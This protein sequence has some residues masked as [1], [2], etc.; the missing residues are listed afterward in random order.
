LRQKLASGPY[1]QELIRRYLLDNPHRVTLTLRPDTTMQARQEEETAARLKQL[2][3]SLDAEQIRTLQQQAQELRQAQ[4]AEDD[5][6]CL[7]TLELADIPPQ[8]APIVGAAALLEGRP[9]HWFDQPTNGIGYV[10][11]HLSA[12]GLPTTQLPL[13]P[14]FCTLLGQIGAAGYSYAEMAERMEAA[15]GGINARATIL[16]L[17]D[18]LNGSRNLISLK[19]KA[20]IRNQGRMFEILADLCRDPDFSDLK[21]LHTV[22]NQVKTSLENSIPGSG[23]SYAARSAAS[24]LTPGARLRELWNGM[25]QIQLIKELAERAPE[26]LSD[27][28]GQM[29]D[30]A[31]RLLRRE[32]ISC[33][34][35]A[36]Q[37][38]FAEISGPLGKFFAALPEGGAASPEPSPAFIPHAL[39]K[40]W[41]TSVPVNYVSRVFRAV[42]YT[43]PDSAAL[44]VL[45]KLLRAG[46]LHRE[47]RE[48]G[49][50]Y[51]GLA[52]YSAE[53][54]IF[55]LLSYRDPHLTRTLR[56][57]DDAVAWVMAGQFEPEQIKEA[58]LSIFSE[59]DR[60]LSPGSRGSQEFA[61]IEQ[62]LTLGMRN[63]LRGQVLAMDRDTLTQVA[64]RYL[65]PANRL[66]SVGVV[67]S[68]TA[69]NQANRELGDD[70][71]VIEKI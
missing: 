34:I 47:L 51:G 33:A 15:T 2:R 68:E 5:L 49:G 35:T 45:S 40:G 70:P 71:L 29:R 27:F 66:S 69:L 61:N 10:A 4:E 55:S 64:A 43:H 24:G 39:R 23:H 67:A 56:V 65:A 50:A 21:R 11:L 53:S 12:A 48:K 57:Y 58:I 25:E 19:G 9:V 38:S 62:G 37:A 16:D 59:L 42:P 44:M 30:L 52:S 46:Y 32:R 18:D 31:K 6:S 7:P 8:E 1:F 63:T 54:G 14:I 36:E 26:E 28:A 17:V 41:A 13:V 20:L 22:L 3:Q 60:P